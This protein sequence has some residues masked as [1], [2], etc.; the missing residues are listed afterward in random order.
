[1]LVST[2]KIVDVP[3]VDRGCRTKITVK[4]R[5]ARKMFEGWSH[6]LHRVIFYGN[7]LADTRR[8]ARFIGVDVFEEG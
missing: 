4:V 7:H 5:D 1:M 6:G 8:L 3:D 2:G